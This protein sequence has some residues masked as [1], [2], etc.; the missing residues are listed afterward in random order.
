MT[1]FLP[2][3]PMLCLWPVVTQRNQSSLPTDPPSIHDSLVDKVDSLEG[4]SHWVIYR[5]AGEV[6]N[7]GWWLLAGSRAVSC[8]LWW[9]LPWCLERP[10]DGNSHT[11]ET[12]QGD[13]SG[14]DC[15][16]II[17]TQE[18]CRQMLTVQIELKDLS[19]LCYTVNSTKIGDLYMKASIWLDKEVAC[20]N[21]KKLLSTICLCHFT[22]SLSI[23]V[24]E[25]IN[26]YPY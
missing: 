2:P 20:I 18:R 25:N 14:L 6:M 17:W 26:Q 24:N 13:N 9:T 21:D 5:K 1:W 3:T 22:F 4:R 8:C 10:H 15:F 16:V 11:K 23:N 7:H 12:G 19:C